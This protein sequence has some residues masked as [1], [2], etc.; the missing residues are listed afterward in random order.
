MIKRLS[1]AVLC[2]TVS[3]SFL[4]TSHAQAASSFCS[5]TGDYCVSALKRN[6]RVYLRLG[7][8]GHY[9]DSYRLCVTPPRGSRECKRFRVREEDG[10]YGSKVRW[11]AHFTNHGRGTYRARWLWG[12]GSGSPSVTFRR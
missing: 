4:A 9:F 11:S 12:S 8:A 6:G 2:L 3:M 10:F 5:E 7:L 1:L